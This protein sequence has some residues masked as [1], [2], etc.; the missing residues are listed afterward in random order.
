MQ[1]RIRLPIPPQ[2]DKDRKAPSL[3]LPVCMHSDHPSLHTFSSGC[4][5]SSRRQKVAHVLYCFSLKKMLMAERSDSAR[6]TRCRLQ[7]VK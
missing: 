7:C 4:S 1:C 6:C 3:S 5:S 2:M